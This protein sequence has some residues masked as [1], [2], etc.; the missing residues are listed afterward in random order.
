M[1][2]NSSVFHAFAFTGTYPVVLAAIDAKGCSSISDTLFLLVNNIGK[3]R[4]VSRFVTLDTTTCFLT[5]NYNFV[6]ASYISGAGFINGA[7]WNFG[8]GNIDVLNTSIYGKK[9]NQV[10]NYKVT[11]TSVSDAG[12]RDSFSLVVKVVDDSICNPNPVGLN[13][14]LMQQ[15]LVLYPNPNDGSF[16]I[17]A[18]NELGDCNVSVYDVAGRLVWEGQK[19]F[20]LNQSHLLELDFLKAGNYFIETKAADGKI[21]RNKFIIHTS[22]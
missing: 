3:A 14:T 4:P 13:Q 8:D 6:N 10:G 18:L 17:K 7:I 22:K 2:N 20:G 11:L 1:I 15:G 5:Q 19:Y 21:N 9:Y 16:Y 12:C